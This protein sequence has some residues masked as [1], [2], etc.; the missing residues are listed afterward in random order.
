MG[1]IS[2]GSQPISA[3]P[4]SPRGLAVEEGEWGRPGHSL[5]VG[6]S[7]PVGRG[8]FARRPPQH[9]C[10]EES[11][12][13]PPD[14]LKPWTPHPLCAFAK[15]SSPCGSPRER[16]GPALGVVARHRG[17]GAR[18]AAGSAL[19][20]KATAQILATRRGHMMSLLPTLSN[21]LHVN[22]PGCD[23]LKRQIQGH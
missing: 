15:Q 7:W 1:R 20:L 4:E 8:I 22:Q 23:L 5:S 9:R 16:P 13:R 18:P 17:A 3:L 2:S 21:L 14:C 10:R 19:V 6:L 11:S 12:C